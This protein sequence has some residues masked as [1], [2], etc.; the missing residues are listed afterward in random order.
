MPKGATKTPVI[1]VDGK[2]CK[3]CGICIA[4]CPKG[5]LEAGPIGEVIIKRA[6]DCN[7]C[8]LCE[9]RCPDYAITVE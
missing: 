8:R 3:L 9:L 2:R 4:F 5:V 7:Y 1:E 6:E